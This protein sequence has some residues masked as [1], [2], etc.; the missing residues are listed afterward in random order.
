MRSGVP[1]LN[2]GCELETA[3]R[4]DDDRRAVLE[5]AQLLALVHRRVAGQAV[6]AAVAQ[7]QQHVQRSAAGCWPP[8]PR[9]PAPGPGVGRRAACI[10]SRARSLRQNRRSTRLQRDRVDV[11]GVAADVGHIA[12]PAVGRRME[13]VVHRRGQAQRDVDAVA[14][15]GRQRIA[16]EQI[17]QRVRHALGL[18]QLRALHIAAGADDGVAGAGDHVGAGVDH[19]RA[20]HEL[21]RE[22]GVQAV[23]VLQLGVAQVQVGE[24]P[25]DGDADSRASHG[26][27]IWLNQPMKRVSV[28]RGMR[29]VSRKFRSSCCN[30]RCVM[31]GLFIRLSPVCL[32]SVAIA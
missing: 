23:E 13:A 7:V 5:P 19:A 3:R 32:Q 26:L 9:P 22:T 8:A 14:E 4:K 25:P 17:G 12:Q 10:G 24:Q 15:V 11:P 20:G 18:E 29:L 6:R 21:A 27:R 1:G 31:E 16:A 28:M 2:A 30:S